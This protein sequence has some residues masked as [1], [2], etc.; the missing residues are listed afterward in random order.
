[1]TDPWTVELSGVPVA[2]LSRSQLV[3]RVF[4]ALAQGE[5]GWIVTANLDFLYRCHSAPSTVDLYR[6]ADFIVADGLPLVWASRLRG[7][8]LPERVAGSELV[9]SLA[10]RATRE[11]RSLYFLGGGGDAAKR[12]AEVLRRRWPALRIVG[13]SSPW[14]S[15][16]PTPEE[17]APIRAELLAVAPDLVYVALGSPKQERLITNLRDALPG[18]W[19]LGVGISLSFI[20]GDVKRAP[21]WM[22]RVGL[23]WFHRLLQ[24]PRRLG[25]RYLVQNIPFTF[26]LLGKALMQRND[27]RNRP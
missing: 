6:Q 25:R 21:R 10:E 23:E 17:V 15:S 27:T 26:R 22:Q 20:A 13:T 12:A 9:W 24:E 16:E 14:I 4:R 5:G 3:D 19:M 2:A 1:M 7:T 18:A 11:G 8:P